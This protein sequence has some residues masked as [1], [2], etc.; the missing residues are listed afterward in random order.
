M[1]DKVTSS[2]IR[3]EADQRAADKGY[4]MDEA[5]GDHICNFI[6]TQLCLYEGDYAG[7]PIRLLDWQVELFYRLFGWCKYSDFYER[8]IRRFRI[9][10]IWLPKKNGKSPT[11]AAVGLYLLAADGEPGN[12][13]YSA[14]RDA[15]QAGIVHKNARML[16]EQSPALR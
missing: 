9:A 12:H 7:K 11:G 5:R 16:V 6:E 8:N 13:I 10:S 15:K 1:T 2:W 4:F 3:N 14:A